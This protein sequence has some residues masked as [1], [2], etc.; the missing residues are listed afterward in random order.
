MRTASLILTADFTTNITSLPYKIADLHLLFA[1]INQRWGGRQVSNRP[2]S[3][4][5]GRR[6]RVRRGQLRADD[7]TSVWHSLTVS[8]RPEDGIENVVELFADI[9]G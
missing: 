5:A 7:G 8:Q 1:E 9:L 4:C 6:G 3:R 2:E